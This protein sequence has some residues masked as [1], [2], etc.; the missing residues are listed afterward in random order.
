[1]DIYEL[2]ESNSGFLDTKFL[3]LGEGKKYYIT[4][5][6]LPYV[7]VEVD[8]TDNPFDTACIFGKFLC[9]GL[10]EKTAFIN[11]ETLEFRF[12]KV[13]MYFGYFVI[14]ND[15]L[16]VLSGVGITAYDRDLNI[17]WEN[18]ELAVDGVCIYGISDDGKYLEIS[19]ELDPPDGWVDKK[20]DIMTGDEYTS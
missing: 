7:T 13:E 10:Y 12:D 18:S 17:L 14:Y 20:I 6:S 8:S 2:T 15:M 19:C 11:L 9:I 1:M 3:T 5:N 4:K 16:F